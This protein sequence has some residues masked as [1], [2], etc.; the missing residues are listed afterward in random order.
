M[1][2]K[3]KAIKFILVYGKNKCNKQKSEKTRDISTK[4]EKKWLI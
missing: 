3:E 4:T 2:K 1:Y